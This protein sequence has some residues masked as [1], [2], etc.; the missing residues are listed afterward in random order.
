MPKAFRPISLL[1]TISKGL[2]AVVAARLSYMVEKYS[3]LPDNHFGARPR[4]SAEQALNVLVERIYQAWRGGK[5]LSLVSFD[6]KGAFNGVHTNVLT[7][8]LAERG[9]PKPMVEWIGDFVSNRHAQVTVG[10]YE[11]EVSEIEYA[12]IPQGS[13]LS[14]LLYVFYNANLVEKKID[15]RGGAIGFVDDFNA[16]VV[17][18]DESETTATIQREIIPHAERWARQSGATFEADKTSFIHFTKRADK[19]DTRALQFGDTTILPRESIKVL[20][21]TLDKKLAM[22][23]HISR[24]VTKG[25]RACFSLQAIKGTRP[26]QMRQLF[27]SCVL[28]IIDY[29]AS[30]WYGPGKPGV[31]RLTHALE[32]VQRLGARLILRAWKAVSLPILEAEAFLEPTKERLDKKVITHTVKLISLP[33][34]NPARKAL[35]HALDVCRYISPLS[36]VCIVAKE[37]LKPKGSRPPTGNPAWIQPP[38]IDHSYRVKIKEKS[39]AIKDAAIIAGANILGLYADA[40]VTKRLASIAVVRRTGI[41]TQVVRQDSIG[42]ASTCGVLSAEIAAIAAALEYALEHI[43][44]LPQLETLGLVVFSDSQQALRAIQAGNDART[45]RALLEKIA[46]SIEAL[47]RK[48]IDVRFKWSPGHEGIVGNEEANDAAREASSQEGKPTAQARER[49]RE[50][51]GVIRLINRDRSENPTLF[52]TTRLPGQYTW[53]MDQALPGKHTLRLYRSLTSDQAA[54]LI[55]A[56]TGHCRLNQYLSRIGVVDEAKCSCG[57]DEETIRHLILSCP[58]WTDE[59]RELHETVGARSGDV[60]Y[61]LGGWGSR[62]DVRTGQLLDGP[63]EK[64]KSDI[65]VVKAT[66]RFLEKTGRLTYQLEAE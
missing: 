53:K 65:K 21:V 44:P 46:E 52:D 10:E 19:D 50:V 32:K 25:T 42:W 13:P 7:Q 38:W 11:S 59:R 60:S 63:K 14:P 55:Q 28:P 54:I 31:V 48:G 4:R 12:G 57:N 9:V 2:E 36:A 26:A 6:V 1:Q 58:R 33:N 18:A 43:K 62:K 39:Q 49:V 22:D 27:R 35:P 17:G 47:S 40:S 23:E 30:A 56:R 45:G 37:R 64:W 20:G 51:V 15:R 41:A 16:W 24:V 8:R 61:L 66:I 3:L 29:A 5:I 34:S